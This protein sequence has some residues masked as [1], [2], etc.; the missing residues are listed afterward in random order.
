MKT[1]AMMIEVKVMINVEK[2]V[3]NINS[4]YDDYDDAKH[5]DS[6]DSNKMRM[7][8]QTMTIIGIMS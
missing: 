3:R 6:Y 4:N 7:M 5:D 8:I 1:T 2:V